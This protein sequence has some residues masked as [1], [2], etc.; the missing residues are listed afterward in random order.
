MMQ[1]VLKG[2]R[3]QLLHQI[4]GQEPGLGIEVLVAGHGRLDKGIVPG[5]H[6]PDS[7]HAH[8]ARS[9]STSRAMISFVY[10]FV[11][12]ARER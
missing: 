3:E 10:T 7:T 2:P 5:P 11:S 4:D 9:V 8:A 12:A 6:F 1:R